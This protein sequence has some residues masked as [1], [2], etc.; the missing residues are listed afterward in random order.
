MKTEEKRENTAAKLPKKTRS[1]I[2]IMHSAK[3]LFEK[4]G[5]DNVTFQMIADESDMCR[6]TVFNHFANL[7]ELLLALSDQEID[8]ISEYCESR[9]LRGRDLIFGIYEKLIEDTSYYPGLT[10]TL[11]NNA[12]LS[13]DENNPVRKLEEMTVRALEEAGTEDPEDKALLIEGAYYGLVNHTHVYNREFDAD[14]LKD[15]F[16]KLADNILMKEV[17]IND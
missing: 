2:K 17:V 16:R 8:D 1:R 12:I 4:Y 9:E 10:S 3:V 5:V 11:V 6:T 15:R 14:E 13:G 7:S